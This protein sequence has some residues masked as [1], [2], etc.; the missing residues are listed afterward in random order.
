MGP[1]RYLVIEFIDGKKETFSFPRQIEDEAAR[2]FAVAQ[3]FKSPFVIIETADEVLI[4][5]FTNIKC[6]RMSSETSSAGDKPL[7]AT[8]IRGAE[9][10]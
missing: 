9:Q 7:P 10:H 2:K 8:A 1:S 4:Y 3:F 6:L 5:P